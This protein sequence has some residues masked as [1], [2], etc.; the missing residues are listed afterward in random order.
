MDKI[1]IYIDGGSRQNPGPSAFGVVFVDESGKV[2]KSYSKYIGY[3]TNN[4]A[5]YQGLIFAL[6]KTKA[7]FGKDK[8]KNLPIEIKSDSKLVV[9]QM[10][11][12]YKVLDP[13]I[14]K[15]FLEAWNL[16]IDYKNLK[17]S[18][19]PREENKLADQQ[20]NKALDSQSRT[21]KIF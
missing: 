21:Q 5:E 7:L 15:L 12:S 10:N 20:V 16:K 19:V 3:A 1:I 17:I 4:E 13:K 8:A 18:L 6:K 14:Q 11:G 2:I 9:S